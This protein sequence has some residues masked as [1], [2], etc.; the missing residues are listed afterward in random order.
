MLVGCDMLA[1]GL[2]DGSERQG[3]QPGEDAA[4]AESRANGDAPT[5][6]RARAEACLSALQVMRLDQPASTRTDGG[7]A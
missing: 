2:A 3:Q 6:A 4:D 5:E 7:E 1:H